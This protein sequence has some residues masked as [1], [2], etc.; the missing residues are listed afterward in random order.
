MA[1]C[2]RLWDTLFSDE[3]RFEFIN[4]VCAAVVVDIRDNIIEGDFAQCMESL[5]G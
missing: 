1:N 3:Q 4:F 5:Q 2:V